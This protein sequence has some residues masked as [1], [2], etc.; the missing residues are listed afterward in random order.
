MF[1]LIV[2]WLIT[3]LGGYTDSDIQEMNAHM[4]KW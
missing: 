2:D 4:E 3:L 1:R